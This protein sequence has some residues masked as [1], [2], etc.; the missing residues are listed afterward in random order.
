M[1]QELPLCVNF[2]CLDISFQELFVENYCNKI[3]NIIVC[4]DENAA[5]LFA[6]NFSGSQKSKSCQNGEEVRHYPHY[7][8]LKLSLFKVFRKYFETFLHFAPRL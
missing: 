4:V 3:I 7:I 8:I 1:E 2:P 5:Q 6:Y